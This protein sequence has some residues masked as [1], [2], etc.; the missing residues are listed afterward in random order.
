MMTGQHPTKTPI[1]PS[2]LGFDFS[3]QQIKCVCTDEELSVIATYHVIFDKDVPHYN[4]SGGV[5]TSVDEGSGRERVWACPIM[6]IEALDLLMTK[7]KNNEID[8]S[9]VIFCLNLKIT[10]DFSDYCLPNME[11]VIFP[12]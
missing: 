10:A 11:T 4:T 3:T 2:F 12:I 1:R 9:Q 8:F 5:N 6:W 7:M